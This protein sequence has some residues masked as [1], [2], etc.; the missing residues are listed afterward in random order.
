MAKYST[1]LSSGKPRD[2]S[3]YG[4]ST[5]EK[6]AEQKKKEQLGGG[7]GNEINNWFG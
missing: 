5:A 6:S 2:E 3:S 1:N 7:G 4:D